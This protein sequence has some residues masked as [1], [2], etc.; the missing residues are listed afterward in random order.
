[1]I[2]SFSSGCLFL[3]LCL[4]GTSL[5]QQSITDSL[6]Q[7]LAQ[8]SGTAKVELQIEL[9][10]EYLSSAPD[11]AEDFLDDAY[12]LSKDI[13]YTSG[14]YQSAM[15]IAQLSKSKQ[16]YW[17]A[18][19]YV[20]RAIEA[21]Q[22]MNSKEAHLQAL[23]LSMNI[24]QLRGKS[25]SFAEAKAEYERIKNE[26][27]LDQLRSE[28][29]YNQQALEKSQIIQ[30]SIKK[31]QAE[32]L[33]SLELTVAEKEQ[34]AALLDTLTQK[35]ELLSRKALLLELE[36]FKREREIEQQEQALR[37]SEEKLKNQ[38]IRNTFLIIIFIAV[39]LVISLVMNNYRLQ[40]RRAEEKA[41][42]QEQLMVQDKLAALGQLT[43]G[44]AHEIKNPLNFVNN[45]SEGS[46]TMTEELEESLQEVKTNIS[47]DDYENMTELIDELKQNAVD[48]SFHG[49]RA[50][51][52]VNAMMDHARSDKVH[53]ELTDLNKLL[54]NSANLA[55]HGYRS[56]QA[57]FQLQIQQDL[58]ESLPKTKV[59]PQQI[60]RA[61]LN[62]INNACYATNEKR[63]Q[64]G[65]TYQ[66]Q[67]SLKTTQEGKN[68]VI[69]IRD[70]G[71]GIP[72]KIRKDIFTPFFTTK[73]TGKGNTGLGL[74]MTHKIIVEEHSGQLQVESEAGS[75]TEFIISLPLKK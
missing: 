53:P 72:E 48:I 11:N 70:N 8:S 33:S 12:D 28:R 26:L 43:A 36:Q 41:Q 34:Q 24:Y 10:E 42:L 50:D 64:E 23:S 21:A 49:K 35:N 51:E 30:D 55:Y 3:F 32:V 57:A 69:R 52:I 1:M 27:D 4:A 58:Q 54:L 39:T 59:I 15:L 45:F 31:E 67:L 47:E 68:I 22:K 75:F 60:S 46:L 38:R 19:R 61:L 73:P 13:N 66:P 14:I 2:N 29:V 44:I 63:V 71:T 37:D 25:N 7:Q 18:S 20:K 56:N 62:I 17:K 16:K 5:A 74:S 65:T 6:Q 40:K 9:A